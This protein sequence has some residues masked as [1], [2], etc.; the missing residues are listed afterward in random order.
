MIPDYTQVDLRMI[1]SHQ[2]FTCSSISPL[3]FDEN[4][5]SP[6]DTMCF[7]M[8]YIVCVFLFFSY[9]LLSICDCCVIYHFIFFPPPQTCIVSIFSVGQIHV[10]PSLNPIRTSHR[11]VIFESR[12]PRRRSDC[13][14]PPGSKRGGAMRSESGVEIYS[15]GDVHVSA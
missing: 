12:E 5:V 15:R 13:G 7:V 11:L 2:L 1:A 9:I 6:M 10:A 8:R 4:L 14:T 3:P